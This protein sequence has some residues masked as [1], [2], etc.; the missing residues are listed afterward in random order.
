MAYN[1]P[2]VADFKSQFLRDFPYG[3]DPKTSVL[4]SDISQ[5]F[6]QVNM[7]INP[8]LFADQGSY[9]FGYNLLTAHYL[10]LSIQRSSQGFN[11][12]YN[13]LQAS[14]GVGAVNEAFSIPQRI[15]DN[16]KFAMLAKTTY[17]AQYLELLLPQL[18]GAMAAFYMP[19]HAL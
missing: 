10:S 17:G 2:S 9:T 11:G 18:T 19:A 8:G 15:L 5:S 1:N 4:D 3:T 14:K 13:F 16:P 12:Q 7:G 6:Q